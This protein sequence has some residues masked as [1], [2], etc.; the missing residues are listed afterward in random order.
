MVYLSMKKTLLFLLLVNMLIFFNCCNS[1]ERVASNLFKSKEYLLKE[2]GNKSIF[3]RGNIV[4]LD[5]LKNGKLNRFIFEK[6]GKQYF[7]IKDT[8]QFALNEIKDILPIDEYD[9]LGFKRAIC[10]TVLSFLNKMDSLQI[11]GISGEFAPMGID[12]KVYLE[13]SGALLYVKNTDNITNPQWKA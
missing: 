5:Y 12:M 2:F 3:T 9:S 8:L 13:G 1:N 11:S 7:F 6:N 10:K 4:F